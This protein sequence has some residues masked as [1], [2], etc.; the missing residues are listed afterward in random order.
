MASSN[1][2]TSSSGRFTF[3]SLQ[4]AVR[5]GVKIEPQIKEI[6]VLL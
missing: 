6:R 2:L 1:D 4:I 5:A 3:G